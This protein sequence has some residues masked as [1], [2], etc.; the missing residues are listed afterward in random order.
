MPIARRAVKLLKERENLVPNPEFNPNRKGI[1]KFSKQSDESKAQ[2]IKENP[3]YGE[4][5]CRCEMV[6]KAEILQAIHNPLGVDTVVGIKYRTRSMMGRCQGGYCQM[7]I[8]QIIQEELGKDI[9]DILYSRKG[10]SMFAGKV[11][12]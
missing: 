4:I 12:E 10:S 3:D 6:T 9:S 11:R 7:R 8:A 2:L 5:I 1:I